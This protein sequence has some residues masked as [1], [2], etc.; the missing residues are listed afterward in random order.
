ML[1]L[2]SIFELPK[3]QVQVTCQ[4][5]S[6]SFSLVKKPLSRSLKSFEESCSLDNLTV[7]DAAN[8]YHLTHHKQSLSIPAFIYEEI[9]P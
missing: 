8:L 1:K 9:S 6:I 3:R 7:V 2:Q 5:Q 4:P